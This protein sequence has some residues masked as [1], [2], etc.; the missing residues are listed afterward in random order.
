M[1]SDLVLKLRTRTQTM[2]VRVDSQKL[3]ETSQIKDYI[4]Q[5]WMQ[6]K[7]KPY[8]I[9]YVDEYGEMCLLN[10][11]SLG[12]AIAT[13]RELNQSG[14]TTPV[15]DLFIQAEGEEL[16]L[17]PSQPDDDEIVR[18]VA[19]AST[20]AQVL[21]DMDYM[22]SL[23]AAEQFVESLMAANSDLDVILD[24]LQND[25][26]ENSRE[27]AV[28]SATPAKKIGASEKKPVAK[29]I[30]QTAKAPVTTNKIEASGYQKVGDEAP[31][32]FHVERQVSSPEE[33][34]DMMVDLLTKMGFVDN[35]EAAED[36][37]GS[38][39]NSP[40]DLQRVTD[41]IDDLVEGKEPATTL[42]L[43]DTVKQFVDML[44][45]S[46]MVQDRAAAESL[47]S[48]LMDADQDLGKVFSDFADR[49]ASDQKQKATTKNSRSHRRRHSSKQQQSAKLNTA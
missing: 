2:R 19:V 34:S 22:D 3:M 48:V 46:G 32:Q 15:L 29:S 31:K 26:V 7:G 45:D 42:G 5:S 25:D 44:D 43:N 13:V 41:H 10:D 8:R 36:L 37:V 14:K 11:L 17:S 28:P 4:E 49:T 33:A 16:P 23:D 21:D 47:V 39:I 38:L 24:R 35:K 6:L 9:F 30:Q 27:D 12:D 20:L 1:S 18:D 40:D